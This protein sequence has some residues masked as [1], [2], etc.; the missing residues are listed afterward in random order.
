LQNRNTDVWMQPARG[1]ASDHQLI[2]REVLDYRPDA[3]S[4]LRILLTLS[5]HIDNIHGYA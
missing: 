4:E 5:D 1:V 2:D 3:V